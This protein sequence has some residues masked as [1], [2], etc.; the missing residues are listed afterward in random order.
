MFADATGRP[1]RF[2]ALHFHLPVWSANVVD[3][4]PHPGTA[5]EVT[6]LLLAFAPRIGQIPIHLR[7][8][9][10]GYAFNSMYEAMNREAIAL[11][12]NRIALVEDVDRAWMGVTKMPV[13]PFGMLDDVGRGTVRKI[14]SFW[15]QQLGDPQLEKNE[16]YLR[17]YVDTGRLGRKSGEGFYRYPEPAYRDPGFLE[18]R[19]PTS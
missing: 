10:H 6:E 1:D 14:T 3:V 19:F 16:K 11:A 5:P 4:M 13:G 15:A 12:A 2:A 9:H 7:K 18:G 8:E 17:G